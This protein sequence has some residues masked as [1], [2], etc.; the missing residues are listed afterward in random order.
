[1]LRS[2]LVLL[3]ACVPSLSAMDRPLDQR[4]P[5]RDGIRLSTNVFYPTGNARYP[6][7]LIRT[8]YKKGADLPSNCADFIQHG[9]AVV[10][11]D[12]RGRYASEGVFEPLDQEGPD[13][14][15][16]LNWIAR[17]TWSDGNVGMTGGSYVGIAQWK[18][19][20][21]GN[22]HLKAILRGVTRP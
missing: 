8:P 1:M 19:A 6:T 15:D 18:A 13:G 9:Y 4:V 11:Q 7:I 12:V 5:M 22:P 17:Q 10:V 16:T 14:Y 3:A 21:T 2:A 20:V